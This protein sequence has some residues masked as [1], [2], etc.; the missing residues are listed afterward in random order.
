MF[1]EILFR[2]SPSAQWQSTGLR[3]PSHAKAVKSAGWFRKGAKAR[4]ETTEFK[5]VPYIEGAYE[6]E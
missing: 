3:T 5:V 1:Y 6:E 4:R 2:R